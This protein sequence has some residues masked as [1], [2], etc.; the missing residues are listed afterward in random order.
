MNEQL[1]EDDI[2]ADERAEPVADDQTDRKRPAA[3]AA[4]DDADGTHEGSKA[5]IPPDKKRKTRGPQKRTVDPDTVQ[6]TPMKVHIL[7][8]GFEP[9]ACR[10]YDTKHSGGECLCSRYKDKRRGC[11]S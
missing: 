5:E 10:G 11:G 3:N 6:P 8:G 9:S 2:H 4:Q 7:S 1:N